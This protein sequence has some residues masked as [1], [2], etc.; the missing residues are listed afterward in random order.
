MLPYPIVVPT[1]NIADVS[2]EMSEKA[3]Q[4]TATTLRKIIAVREK[5]ELPVD[6]LPVLIELYGKH[7]LALR[8]EAERAAAEKRMIRAPLTLHSN[9]TLEP[10]VKHEVILRP[11][12]VTYRVE[13]IAIEGDRNHWLVHDLK[14]GNR[15]QF[16]NKQGPARGT[17][18][19][20]GGIL[21]HLRLETCQI[22]MD[23]VMEVEYVGPR[24]EGEVFKAAI[25]GTAIEH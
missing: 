22:S 10:G 18:F 2:E 7:V 12:F 19:G 1:P 14:V 25:V 13:D 15:S 11:Q 3:L 5:L 6:Q 21:E 17:E 4:R 8:A 23:F 24:R 9:K 20:P 16:L